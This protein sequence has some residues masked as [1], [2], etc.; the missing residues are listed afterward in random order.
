M[1]KLE[2][3]RFQVYHFSNIFEHSYSVMKSWGNV[4]QQIEVSSDV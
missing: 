2:F 3:H 4:R 1:T